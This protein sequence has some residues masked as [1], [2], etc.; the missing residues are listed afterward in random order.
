MADELNL[1]IEKR[2]AGRATVKADLSI[3]HKTQ[4]I[5][6]LFGPSGS[7]K[8]TILR[9]L[10]GLERPDAGSI[11]FDDRVWYDSKLRIDQ[12]PQTRRIGYL[13]QDYALFPHLTVLGN[14][15]Y[16]LPRRQRKSRSQRLADLVSLFQLQGLEV[17]YPSQLSG[18]QSQRVA[19]ARAV[20]PEPR[21]L[22]LDEPLSALD[23]PTR[24]QLRSDLR[25]LLLRSGIASLVV[26]HDRIEAIALGDQIAVLAD[27]VIQQ[28]GP[29]QE[30]FGHPAN[31]V[32]AR[33]IGVETVIPAR[34]IGSQNGLFT[35]LAGRIQ[36]VAVDKG[37]IKDS[38]VYLCIR[39]EEVILERAES[40]GG[41]AR[42]HLPGRITSIA[43]EGPVARVTLDCGFSIT[44]LITR[45]SFEELALKVGDAMTAVIKAT[46]IHL[47]PHSVRLR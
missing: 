41:S 29:V 25:G 9:C 44:A 18:G 5:T 20:A 11:R 46:A 39:A 7:G 27:G 30:V 47:I 45:Q 31:H 10:A 33:S 3:P 28:I 12:S 8:T 40:T 2:F 34:V 14:L 26:T 16:G 6:V 22:L 19:L 36:L 38:E 23:G 35:L 24:I 43:P 13:F 17:R 4:S 15:E 32:V 21:L 42:N 1:Q 37:D